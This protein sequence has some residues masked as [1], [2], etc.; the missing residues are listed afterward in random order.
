MSTLIK[1]GS[2]KQKPQ[3]VGL[4]LVTAEAPKFCKLPHSKAWLISRFRVSKCSDNEIWEAFLCSARPCSVLQDNTNWS[5]VPQQELEDFVK[6]A[7][8]GKEQLLRYDPQKLA[9]ALQALVTCVELH[10]KRAF[11][12]EPEVLGVTSSVLRVVLTFGGEEMSELVSPL[13]AMINVCES[14]INIRTFKKSLEDDAT[15]QKLKQI[16]EDKFGKV[17]LT[18]KSR[19]EAAG[20]YKTLSPAMVEARSLAET[21][22]HRVSKVC[23]DVCD[24]AVEDCLQAL[25]QVGGGHAKDSSASWRA[26]LPASASVKQMTE[27]GHTLLSEA[28][29]R[30]LKAAFTRATKEPCCVAPE[31]RNCASAVRHIPVVPCSPLSHLAH[32]TETGATKDLECRFG[33]RASSRSLKSL[34]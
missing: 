23:M 16:S 7:D 22:L 15:Q 6:L 32:S 31:I 3:S 1:C 25:V 29:S 11:D 14:L 30:K 24:R 10:I 19:L 20:S 2:A 18:L 9:K 17:F 12:D 13:Q 8:E 26:N 27:A 28:F 5:H 4:L 34:F 33:T 21:A